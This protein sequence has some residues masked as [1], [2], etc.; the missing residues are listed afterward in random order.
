MTQIRQTVEAIVSKTEDVVKG[1]EPK[2]GKKKKNM[3]PNEKE[4]K[5]FA[6]DHVLA[7]SIGFMQMAILCYEAA[8]AVTEGDIGRFYEIYKVLSFYL[9]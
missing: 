9:I 8:D 5:P 4:E 2:K 7:T 1:K 6:G 3:K